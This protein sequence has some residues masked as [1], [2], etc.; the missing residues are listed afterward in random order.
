MAKNP[1]PTAARYAT[2]RDAII[3][4]IQNGTYPPGSLLPSR[5]QIESHYDVSHRTSRRVLQELVEAGW[6]RSEGTRGYSAT[7]GPN[8][9]S[10]RFAD[11]HP[12]GS[13]F[14]QDA[15]IRDPQPSPDGPASLPQQPYP[16]HAVPLGADL[17]AHLTTVHPAIRVSTE[18]ATLEVAHWLTLQPGTLLLV[19]RR[20]ITTRDGHAPLEMRTSYLADVPP[21]SALAADTP[22]TEPWPEA[23]TTHTG[24]TITT[25]TSAI[26]ARHPD[27]YEAAALRLTPTDCVLVRATTWVDLQSKPVTLTVS[28]WPAIA[29]SVTA[30][31]HGR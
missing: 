13:Q 16:V 3:A 11:T 18:P 20:L 9:E 26:N 22:L 28:V 31:N 15:T 24:R 8:M 19:R 10:N 25:A 30:P 5:A 21:G 12:D 2:I 23:V 17:P 27:R 6:A 14:D 7:S 1:E 29:V 4:G